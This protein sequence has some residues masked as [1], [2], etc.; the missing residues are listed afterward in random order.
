MLKHYLAFAVEGI[1]ALAL[2]G[3]A[4]AFLYVWFIITP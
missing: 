2:L 3:V 4:Y 1:A